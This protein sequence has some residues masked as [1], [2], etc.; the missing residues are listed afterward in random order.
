MQEVLVQSLIWEDP[1]AT[2]QLSPRTTTIEP[3][4][5][6]LLVPSTEAH[7]P[8]PVLCNRGSHRNEKPV[9]RN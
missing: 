4:L 9:Y 2:E 1:Q 6:S 5:E 3:V 8:R 7:V